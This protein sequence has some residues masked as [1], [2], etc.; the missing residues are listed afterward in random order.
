MSNLDDKIMPWESLN[1]PDFDRFNKEFNEI[2]NNPEY[3]ESQGYN[4]S[5]LEIKDLYGIQ[6]NIYQKIIDSKKQ[7]SLPFD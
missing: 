6:M 5:K 4:H 1:E 3:C 7:Y 2:I